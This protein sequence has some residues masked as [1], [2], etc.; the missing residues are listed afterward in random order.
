MIF[1]K[2]GMNTSK[3]CSSCIEKMFTTYW[4]NVHYVFLQK[5]KL[6]RFLIF[7]YTQQNIFRLTK[8]EKHDYKGKRKKFDKRDKK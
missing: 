2:N 4:K 1:I 6:K 3:S 5:E 8:K 7:I